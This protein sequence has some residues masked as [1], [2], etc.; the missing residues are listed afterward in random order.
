MRYSVQS[1]PVARSCLLYFM[2]AGICFLC[3]LSRSTTNEDERIAILLDA[4]LLA[5]RLSCM[6]NIP[7]AR[8][9]SVRGYKILMLVLVHPSKYLP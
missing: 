3:E 2:T 9:C 8:A 1:P 5:E 4:L 6:L 7:M